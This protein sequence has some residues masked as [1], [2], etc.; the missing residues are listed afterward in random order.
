MSGKSL[1]RQ[2]EMAK[3]FVDKIVAEAKRSRNLDPIKIQKD[4]DKVVNEHFGK[5]SNTKPSF[6]KGKKDTQQSTVRKVSA[7]S[8]EESEAETEEDQEDQT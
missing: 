3:E 1:A 7:E 2:R 6:Q 4:W 5:K 8:P